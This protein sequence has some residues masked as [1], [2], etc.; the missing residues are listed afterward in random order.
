ML[1]QRDR[2]YLSKKGRIAMAIIAMRF[3]NQLGHNN[4]AYLLM[5][6]LSLA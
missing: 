2:N 3:P 6:H 4:P 5:S 1:A